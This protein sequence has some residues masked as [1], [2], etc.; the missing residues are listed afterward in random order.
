MP[1]IRDEIE[2]FVDVWNNYSIRSQKNRPNSVPGKLWQ[3][4]DYLKKDVRDYKCTP[5]SELLN[6]IQKDVA[7]YGKY[8]LTS[9]IPHTIMYAN[10]SYKSKQHSPSRN[11][12][13]VSRKDSR[14][15]SYRHNY[16]RTG[17][18]SLED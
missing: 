2:A 13:M 6:L 9:T 18:R 17:T 14:I 5:D 7:D 16:T 8:F 3:F 1:I 10:A 4:Y 11:L 15:N 12:P